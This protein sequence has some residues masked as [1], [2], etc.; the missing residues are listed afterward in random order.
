VLASLWS[1]DDKTTAWLKGDFLATLTAGNG[2]S[3]VLQHAEVA[4]IEARRK[5]HGAAHLYFWAAFS[6]TAQGK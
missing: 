6:L 1:V 4:D 3:Q 2:Q 5:R